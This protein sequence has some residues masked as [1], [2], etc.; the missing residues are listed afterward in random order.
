M[1]P[2]P[3]NFRISGATSLAGYAGIA[4]A[5]LLTAATL[6]FML[7]REQTLRGQQIE[8][9]KVHAQILAGTVSAAL[10]FEDRQTAQD[11]V[12]TLSAIP[13]LLAGA[14]YDRAGNRFVGF[15]RTGR[16]LPDKVDTTT[17]RVVDQ[18]VIVT[19]PVAQGSASLGYVSLK[20][21][22]EPAGRS[23][24]RYT[25]MAVLVVLAA[26]AIAAL[27]LGQSTLGRANRKLAAQADLLT[28]ANRKLQDE[29][30]E[31]EK[32]E[33]A[34][35][36]SQKMEA[37]GQLAGGIAHDF[38]NLLGI[39]KGNLHLLKKRSA[40]GSTDTDRYVA[41][42]D[43]ALTRAA[44]LTQRILAYSRRQDLSPSKVNLSELITGMQ[45]LIKHSVDER[46]A[47]D[48]RLDADWVVLCDVSQMESVVLNLTNN[49]GDAMTQGGC[50]TLATRNVTIDA[51]GGLDAPHR[52]DYVEITVSDT[53]T[54]MDA[55]TQKK[56]MDP[57]FTTKPVG[58]GTGLG[59][60]TSF[61]Y[62][63]QSLGHM[64][65]D[66][67]VGQGTTITILMPRHVEK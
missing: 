46:V 8:Q 22:L 26:L 31:R 4:L 6:M 5:V 7:Y 14:V 30:V 2:V 48:L 53:G 17:T 58:R 45:E 35:R 51:D 38:N 9:I 10:A 16:A 60:S 63:R 11:S 47:I 28:L 50:L 57:F 42:A 41:S 15:T 32:A 25:I 1:T 52:G 64:R 49:A 23:T 66:S 13:S 29:I 3:P 59:L 44:T 19:L 62:V 39:A 67:V 34:L 56:A 18:D 20:A 65:I 12:N 40:Q 55:E 54:G 27:I 21:A 37:I 33:G 61:G 24:A 36:Q 43:E